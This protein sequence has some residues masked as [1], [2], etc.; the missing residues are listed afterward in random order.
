MP[1]EPPNNL[2]SADQYLITVGKLTGNAALTDVVLFSTFKVLASCRQEVGQAIYY[3]LDSVP[4][5][6]RLT[7]RV[8]EAVGDSQDRAIVDEIIKAVEAA[9]APRNEL[10]HAL[11]TATAGADGDP[12]KPWHRVSLK[13]MKQATRPVTVAYLKALMEASGDAVRTA[14][15]AFERL[16]EKKGVTADLNIS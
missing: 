8:A 6:S 16:C 9:H 4:A 14:Y 13:A 7:R 1:R 12:G 2:A 3:A 5:K 15:A 10:A 11:L